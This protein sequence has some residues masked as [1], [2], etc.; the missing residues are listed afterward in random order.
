MRLSASKKLK[1]M[2]L[3][4]QQTGLIS[5]KY[6]VPSSQRKPY[7]SESN[8]R[9]N[10]ISQ[11]TS[12][13][14]QLKPIQT[15]KE[16]KVSKSTRPSPSK[17][18]SKKPL[19][20]LLSPP[21]EL[22]SS[23]IQLP[24]MLKVRKIKKRRTQSTTYNPVS[25][26]VPSMQNI[27]NR[28]I[29]KTRTG[30]SQGRP[31]K[32]NQ[33]SYII[34]QDLQGIAGCYLFAVCDGHGVY[35]HK[36]SRLLKNKL[37]DCLELLM[38]HYKNSAN[39]LGNAYTEAIN[40][41]D[42]MLDT[43]DIDATFS[44]ST[45]VSVVIQGNFL[46]CANIGDSRAVVG[47]KLNT[48]FHEDLSRD[49][50]PE[51]PDESI[52]ILNCGGRIMPYFT[53]EGIPA[54]PNRVWLQDEYIPGLAM[55]RSFG[56]SVAA[57]VG[58]TNVPEFYSKILKKDDKFVIVASDGLWEFVSSQEA[59]EIVGRSID[60]GTSQASCERLVKEAV[61]RWKARDGGIDDI[62]VLVIFIN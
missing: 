55:S 29:Y 25:F 31:K 6:E 26:Q 37:V 34:H 38:D 54:G 48:W 4:F 57:S 17:L 30:F 24:E 51:L 47:K 9:K 33:D 12:P 11:I 22:V 58:V 21:N 56:D 42:N 49:H 40:K 16:L 3:V 39:P 23:K 32:E 36:V 14:N 13:K 15:V 27:V 5:P 20:S 18:S 43:N 61:K 2:N 45:I 1:S 8:S 46:T 53:Q 41:C 59:V 19:F 62:T 60:T 28:C 44:G 10:L 52:R 35:G 50:K 7:K